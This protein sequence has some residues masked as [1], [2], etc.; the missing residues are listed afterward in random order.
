MEESMKQS[1][2]INRRN[3]QKKQSGEKENKENMV[4][5]FCSKNRRLGVMC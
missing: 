5:L 3:E 1:V 4:D 2:E